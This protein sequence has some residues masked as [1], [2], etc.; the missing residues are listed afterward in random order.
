M[1]VPNMSSPLD[2]PSK[3][4]FLIRHAES[5]ENRR[6]GSLKNVVSSLGRFSIPS[7]R[8]VS[9][10]FGL[11]NI[12]AQ[13]DSQ[14]SE[15]GRNQ[16]KDMA[17]IIQGD[18]KFVDQIEL[19]VHSPLERAKETCFGLFPSFKGTM[20]ELALVT[21]KTPTEWLPGQSKYLQERIS[22]FEEWISQREEETIA[23][24][25]HSQYFK[26]MLDL[27]Y[28]FGNCD[29]WKAKFSCNEKKW[30]G[31]ENVFSLTGDSL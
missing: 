26:A 27:D 11:L 14:V 31:L 19:L 21:E 4:I 24:V 30:V 29:V 23:V 10:S 28:K 20:E 17:Q 9:T 15:K 25:G 1:I 22:N 12:P 18:S 7:S 3:T 13:V 16:I 2:G 8:D 6:M 5:E